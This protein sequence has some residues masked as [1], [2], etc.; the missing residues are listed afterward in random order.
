[1]T[2]SLTVMILE[3]TGDMQYVLP[4]MLTVMA[5]RLVGN[6][7]TEGS[8]I[9]LCLSV[10][11][12]YAMLCYAMLCYA[13]LCYAMLCYAMLCYAMLCYA[14]LCYALLCSKTLIKYIIIT[15]LY[16][17]HIHSRHLYFLEEDE[18]V[19]KHVELHDLTVSEIM[20][21]RPICLR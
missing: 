19:S 6:V 5:A 14:M 8:V 9:T 3:A 10:L 13:M 16:D 7:F 15:G 1:M 12:C 17:I 4:L 21:K 20:T 2:I 18:G 11:L